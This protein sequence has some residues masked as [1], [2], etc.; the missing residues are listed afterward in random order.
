MLRKEVILIIEKLSKGN[1]K[2][3]LHISLKTGRF[4][5]GIVLNYEDED[6]LSFMDDVIGWYPILYS[7]IINIEL[8]RE[9]K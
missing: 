2:Q 7:L 5:N 3:K 6:S 4:Y 1:K 9:K 8:M